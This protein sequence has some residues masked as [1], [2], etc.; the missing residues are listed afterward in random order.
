MRRLILAL[1]PLLATGC[2]SLYYATMSTMGVE[3]RHILVDRVEDARESQEEAKERFRTALDR[4][5]ALT[6]TSGGELED[7]YAALR[8][9]YERSERA[10]ADV[11]DRI[12]RIEDVAR[13]LFDEWEAECEEY[14][15]PDLRARSLELLL[16]TRDHYEE[17]MLAMRRAEQRMQ[18]I[19][20]TFR[21]TVTLLKH[22]LTAKAVGDLE[23]KVIEIETDVQRLIEDMEVSIAE[24][25]RFIEGMGSGG[26]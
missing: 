14:T 22:Q 24:A 12:D 18:P 19:L 6:G 9:E 2:D 7:A 16:D 15:D 25:D 20:T 21:D 23:G 13:D 26:G 10:A 3:K 4:F 11:A 8:D 17:M 5:L 1:L